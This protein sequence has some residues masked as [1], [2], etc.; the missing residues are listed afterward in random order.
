MINLTIH[1]IV[2]GI[3]LQTGD[4]NIVVDNN[5]TLPNQNV[6]SNIQDVLKTLCENYLALDVSWVDLQIIHALSD[7][8]S[9]NTN[10][11]YAALIPL[12]TEL[13]SLATFKPLTELQ[14]LSEQQNQ[15]ILDSI[16]KLII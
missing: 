5:N 3:N 15:I 13:S 4:V 6:D 16:R 1:M 11:F 10:L 2:L 7:E 9:K 14:E 12:D 8:D